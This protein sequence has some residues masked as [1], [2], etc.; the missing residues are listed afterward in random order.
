MRGARLFENYDPKRAEAERRRNEA[1]LAEMQKLSQTGSFTWN[2]TTGEIVLSDESYRI[3]GYEPSIDTSI[4][5]LVSRTH[6]DDMALIERILDQ[7]AQ[8]RKDIDFEYRLL[9][10]DG[11]VKYLRAAARVLPSDLGELQF[12]GAISDITERKHW[13]ERSRHSESHLRAIVDTIPAIVWSTRPDGSNDFHNG[14]LLDYTGFSPQ[15]AAGSGWRKMIHPDDAERHG[16]AWR[17]AVTTGAL[18]ECESRLRRF[19]GEYRWFLARAEPFRDEQGHII[20]WYGTNV[21]IDDR[22][23]AEQSLRRSEAYLAE[24]QRLSHTGSF[25]WNASTGEIF[26]WSEEVYRIFG[27]DPA[28]RMTSHE[29]MQRLHPDDIESVRQVLR[30]AANRKD[31]DFQ[32][33]LVMP[34]GATK[35]IHITAHSVPSGSDDIHFLGAVSDITERVT[36]QEMLNGVQAN[37]AHASRVSVL[38]ELTASIAHEIAQ[39][40]AAIAASSGAGLQW[41]ERTE[42]DL[43]EVRNATASI[44]NNVRRATEIIA[45]IRSMATRTL[46]EHT[47]LSLDDIIREALTFLRYEV[48]ARNA[49]IAH[50]TASIEPLVLADRTQVQQVL[51]NLVMNAM[52]ALVQGQER[53]ITIQTT[54]EEETSVICSVEDTG[55]GIRPEHL[56]R[57]FESFFTTKEG[58]MGMGLA[59]C[60][61]ILEAHGGNLTVQNLEGGCG[62]RFSFTLPLAGNAAK[63][64]CDQTNVESM[65]DSFERKAHSLLHKPVL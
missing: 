21:D 14:R 52:Q 60:R 36:A 23:R 1:C 48:Q 40:L 37:F 4:E 42:P 24:A 58:G 9:M 12:V 45:R 13:E 19:D 55:A 47:V 33:R 62:A 6:P 35:H 16:E 3:L 54:I 41:L 34:A 50:Y 8:D 5:I 53:K 61:S 30:D 56:P 49:H 10:P 25:G 31:F 38:G 18:F 15:E 29:A 59:L 20:K 32:C 44:V 64:I 7:I 39:P 51:V 26:F 57:V 65:P 63:Q 46:P 28:V 17:S 2:V 22:K 27:R 43:L 11:L